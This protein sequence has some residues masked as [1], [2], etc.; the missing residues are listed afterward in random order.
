[1]YIII[2]YV[3]YWHNHQRWHLLLYQYDRHVLLTNFEQCIA[4]FSPDDSAEDSEEPTEKVLL[5]VIFVHMTHN[6]FF[7]P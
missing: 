2:I 7:P 1:L 6:G 4:I 5:L 3:N